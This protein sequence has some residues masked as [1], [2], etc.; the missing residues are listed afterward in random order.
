[1]TKRRSVNISMPKPCTEDWDKMIPNELGRHCTSCNK[2]VIDFSLFTNK[3]LIE[4]FEKHTGRICGH[5][6]SMQVENEISYTEPSNNFLYKLLFGTLMVASAAC[7]Y[8]GNY[9]P[10]NIPLAT[11]FS[12]VGS[13]KNEENKP[14]Y[15]TL[16]NDTIHYVYGRVH[17]GG[18]DK[19][20]MDAEVNIEG[21]IDQNIN[22]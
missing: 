8:N 9:N 14:D 12:S 3:Q 11:Q 17:W 20:V 22:G 16:S 1:M 6:T 5:Y 15:F 4:F 21:G 13:D 2:T 7:S 10:N 19:G 18:Y